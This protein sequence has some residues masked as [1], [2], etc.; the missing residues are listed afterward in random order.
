M[1]AQ[2][3]GEPVSSL[4]FAKSAAAIREIVGSWRASHHSVALVPTM[5]SLHSGH[6]ALTKFAGEHADSVVATIFV[7][8][9][10]FAPGEDYEEYP[11]V[12]EQDKSTLAE[13][14][15]VN[16]LFAPE[17][18]QIYPYGLDQSIQIAMPPLSRELCGA[19]RPGHFDGVAGVVLRLLNIVQ[20]DMLVMGQKDYQQ[21]VLIEQLV[22]DLCLPVRVIGV[23]TTREEDGLAMSSRNHYLSK[24][25]RAQAPALHRALAAVCETIRGGETDFEAVAIRAREA[26]EALGFVVEYVEVRVGTTLAPT[27]GHSSSD[28]LIVLAAVRLGTTRLIDNMRVWPLD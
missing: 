25:E 22:K 24:T 20:P 7:N 26:L 28:D 5:G 16:A 17:V 19:Y 9:T 3:L 10:Q 4:I 11:R 14:K 1:H 18:A 21:L 12:L 2:R 23:P 13:Q 27:H 6:L 8:P 15:A